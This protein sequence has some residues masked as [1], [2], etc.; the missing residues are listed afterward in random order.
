MKL[1]MIY[2]KIMFQMLELMFYGILK[3]NK[4]IIKKS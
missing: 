3:A 2:I 1:L 4:I